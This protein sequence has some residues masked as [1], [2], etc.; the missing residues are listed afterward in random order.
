MDFR[1]RILGRVTVVIEKESWS[2]RISLNTTKSVRVFNEI[3]LIDSCLF[4]KSHNNKYSFKNLL[5]S[6][7]EKECELPTTDSLQVIV[8]PLRNL[9]VRLVVLNV[10]ENCQNV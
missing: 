2:I 5:N 7:L 9:E 1:R 3:L 8:V 6:V 4:Q 10:V